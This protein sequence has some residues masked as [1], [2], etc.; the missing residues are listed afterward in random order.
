VID[1]ET[2]S[3]TNKAP[4]RGLSK[5][6]YINCGIIITARPLPA[7][8]VVSCNEARSLTN[9]HALLL[10]LPRPPPFRISVL[11]LI[12]LASIVA[13]DTLTMGRSF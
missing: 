6:F 3:A 8:E 7:S 13:G 2:S 1:N 5:L 10:R 4:E 9:E 12:S 11:V